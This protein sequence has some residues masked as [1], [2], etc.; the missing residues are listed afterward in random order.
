MSDYMNPFETK[1]I[2]KVKTDIHEINRNITKIKTD[3]ITMKA[4]ISIIKDL[5]KAK[6]KKE[7]EISKGWIW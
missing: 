6:E 4:D 2:E 1:P 7:Q 3:L 5:I